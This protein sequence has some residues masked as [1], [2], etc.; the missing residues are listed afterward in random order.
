[1]DRRVAE[2]EFTHENLPLGR[3][4]VTQGGEGYEGE[5]PTARW[6]WDAAYF[7]SQWLCTHSGRIEGKRVVELGSGTGLVGL[8]AAAL[9]ADVTVT[10]LPTELRL[11]RGNIAA[12]RAAG[13]LPPAARIAAAACAWGSVPAAEELGTF[14]VVLISDC[15]YNNANPDLPVALV[16]TVN[17]LVAPGGCVLMGYHFRESLMTDVLFFDTIEESF[18]SINH[19]ASL[20]SNV[21]D[22]W[23]LEY[24]R[25]KTSV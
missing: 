24:V 6:V 11:L 4:T 23:L 22:M 10:D 19:T 16:A 7:F 20:P 15:V 25:K 3:V 17:Q 5:D 13:L 14:D 21:K 1:M 18:D 8:V 9:G 2:V 12:N